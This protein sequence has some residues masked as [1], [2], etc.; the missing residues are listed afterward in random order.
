MKRQISDNENAIQLKDSNFKNLSAQNKSL[1]TLKLLLETQIEDL[2]LEKVPLHAKFND[3]EKQMISL[4][5]D[6]S[7]ERKAVTARENERDQ[8][9]EKV[10]CQMR[11]IKRLEGDV[12]A[13]KREF[14]LLAGLEDDGEVNAKIDCLYRKHITGEKK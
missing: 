6:L 11:R 13:M 8:F 2:R 3:L 1:T 4:S 5:Y 10:S 12:R 14:V 9:K 7:E